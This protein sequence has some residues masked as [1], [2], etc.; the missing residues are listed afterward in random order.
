MCLLVF[1]DRL[2]WLNTNNEY[3]R[4]QWE[5]F[6]R[7]LQNPLLFIV[8]SIVFWAYSAMI[9]IKKIVYDDGMRF[10][11]LHRH[12][13]NILW[14]PLFYYIIIIITLFYIHFEKSV[15]SL[16]CPV[17][18][19][20]A[21]NWCSYITRSNC[22]DTLSTGNRCGNNVTN[23][24]NWSFVFEMVYMQLTKDLITEQDPH[25]V[26]NKWCS[27]THIGVSKSKNVILQQFRIERLVEIFI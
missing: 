27:F 7:N 21:T 24:Y 4:N 12:I 1:V 8:G 25:C 26:Q 20:Y 17:R 14:Q 5:S 15:L 10:I 11:I 6:Q 18:I 22:L 3:I 19:Y 2:C 9:K 23:E 16:Y 13:F